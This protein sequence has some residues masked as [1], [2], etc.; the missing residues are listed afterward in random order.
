MI[1]MINFKRVKF[2]ITLIWNQTY[3]LKFEPDF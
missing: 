1:Y 3:A 2:T